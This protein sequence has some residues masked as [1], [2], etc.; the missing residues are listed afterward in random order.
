VSVKPFNP[1]KEKNA[2]DRA[3]VWVVRQRPVSWFLVNLGPKLDPPLMKLTGGRIRL[4]AQGPT[5]L[6][7]AT[8][9]KSGKQ[10][11]IPLAYYTDG[12]N[13]ILI[14]STGGAPENPAWYHNLKANPDVEAWTDGE[15]A[16]YRAREAEGE[17]RERLWDL[18]VAFFPGYAD[19]QKRTPDRQIPVMV[20]E[21]KAGW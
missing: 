7:T 20:L 15:P 19:Y 8:G 14:A 11:T 4:T 9:A 6:V 1:K 16:A 3:G 12:D 10:R 5:V 13:V 17:E 2:F 18:A 21:P